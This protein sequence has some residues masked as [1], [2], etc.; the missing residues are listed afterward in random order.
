MN[1]GV[2]SLT[3]FNEEAFFARLLNYFNLK[4]YLFEISFVRNYYTI[5]GALLSEGVYQSLRNWKAHCASGAIDS[6]LQNL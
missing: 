3:S 1:T 6:N 2:K 5:Y 4:H